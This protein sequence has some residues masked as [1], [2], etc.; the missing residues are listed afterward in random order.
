M[1]T[2]RPAQ[3]TISRST[4]TWCPFKE[5][6]TRN[7]CGSACCGLVCSAGGVGLAG[8]VPVA[9]LESLCPTDLGAIREFWGCTRQSGS[10]SYAYF[11]EGGAH[12]C[13][14][15]LRP[16]GDLEHYYKQQRAHKHG[17]WAAL[18]YPKHQIRLFLRDLLVLAR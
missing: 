10:Q 17:D 12:A 16:G 14:T 15:Q 7:P 9:P 2:C 1:A 3:P 11:N 5:N 6:H 13:Y 4:W 18:L 8:G